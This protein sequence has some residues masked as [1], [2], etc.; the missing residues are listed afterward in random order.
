MHVPS[1]AA[2]PASVTATPVSV[3]L[4]VLETVIEYVITLPTAS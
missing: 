4:P 3:W 1:T 2:T